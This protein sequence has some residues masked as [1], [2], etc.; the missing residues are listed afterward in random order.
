M[1]HQVVL[2]ITDGGLDLGPWAQV[3]YAEFDGR[4]RKRVLLKAIASS[5]R[6][7]SGACRFVR[8]TRVLMYT[9]ACSPRRL[10]LQ[11]LPQSWRGGSVRTRFHPLRFNCQGKGVRMA[12]E[13]ETPIEAQEE[14][15]RKAIA[16]AEEAVLDVFQ[17]TK[18]DSLQALR[19]ELADAQLPPGVDRS[20][21]RVAIWRLLG[22][23]QLAL[24]DDRRLAAAG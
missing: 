4:R 12:D 16:A 10:M 20:L 23:N 18:P 2:A 21:L 8:P 9:N 15:D 22:S 13:H 24:T 1:A 5:P 19:R 14:A 6:S 11:E 17:R 7:V 3:F